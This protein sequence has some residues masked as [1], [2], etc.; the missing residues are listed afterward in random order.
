MCA[1]KPTPAG[2][3]PTAKD[4]VGPSGIVVSRTQIARRVANLAEELN[5]YYGRQE[6]TLV[7]VLT[8]SVVFLADLI[9]HL[10]MPVRIEVVRVSSYP[11]EATESC[12]VTVLDDLPDR[13]AGRNVLVVD[14]ILDSGHTLQAVLERI[15]AM[16]PANLRSCVFLRKRR[17]GRPPAVEADY[18]GFDVGDEFVV[19]YGLDFDNRYRD[20]PDVRVL[21][22][23][24]RPEVTGEGP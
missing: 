19:G 15:T 8:G 12:G 6:V 14:D 13:L 1:I 23:R 10:A 20:L 22:R 9:R 2:N 24:A 21:A 18:T 4:P 7:A 3:P 16:G 11:E 5:E 17:P